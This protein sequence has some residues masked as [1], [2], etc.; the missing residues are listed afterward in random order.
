MPAIWL[1]CIMFPR[2]TGLHDDS[3]VVLG[4][5]VVP[6]PPQKPRWCTWSTV[7]EFLTA[8]LFG[9]HTDFVVLVDLVGFG[10]VLLDVLVA[11]GRL[12]NVGER[13]GHTGP[14]CAGEAISFS[15]SSVAAT[16]AVE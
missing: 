14:R 4:V 3:Q 13:E 9:E 2:A 7:D 12:D 6:R 11:L 1:I 5:E 10:F 8:L 15:A 16:C